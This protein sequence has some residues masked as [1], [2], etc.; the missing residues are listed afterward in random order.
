MIRGCILTLSLAVSSLALAGPRLELIKG[1]V[2]VMTGRHETF[3]KVTSP[4][5]LQEKA[6]IHVGTG[7][8]ARVQLDGERQLIL[9]G[10]TRIDIPG[11]GWDHGEVSL[12]LFEE[13]R[14]RWRQ[15]KG[16]AGET[17]LRSVLFELSPPTGDFIF[18]MNPR[19]PQCEVQV[20]EGQIEFGAANAESSVKVGAREKAS[21]NGVLEEGE[22]AVDVLL[23]GRRIPRGKLG[24]P[25]KMSSAELGPYLEEQARKDRE[26]RQQQ[27][28][29]KK[30]EA[31]D[32]KVGVICFSPKARLNECAWIC[33]K[34]PK[35][36][37][38]CQ[39][40]QAGVR[41]VRQRCNAN[42]QWAELSEVP[43]DQAELRCQGVD[44][45]GPC[46]Y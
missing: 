14:L 33:Q 40:S 24:D 3:E 12:V 30:Q 10:D 15:G 22:I 43:R 46:D 25:V 45:V 9:F 4:L 11:I 2:Q 38:T 28:E 13:G 20:L 26:I 27:V 29:K 8:E 18:I 6:R 31:Q 5:N 17:R 34:N 35:G 32:A 21:F 42:G 19:K 39:L 7:G 23:K 16:A 44:Q 41:C 1:P 37:K 36:S